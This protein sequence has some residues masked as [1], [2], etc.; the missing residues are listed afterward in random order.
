MSEKD[1]VINR[2]EAIEAFENRKWFKP[3]FSLKV[4]KHILYSLPDAEPDRHALY[5]Y[6]HSDGMSTSTLL[7]FCRVTGASADWLRGLKGDDANG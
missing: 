5:T 6:H 2:R 3:P 7:R 4:V 1:V